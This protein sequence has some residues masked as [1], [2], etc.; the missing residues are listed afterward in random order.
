MTTYL[1][2][3]GLQL[4]LY[5]FVYERP[6]V[7]YRGFSQSF[8]QSDC[9][10]CILE[11]KTQGGDTAQL[12]VSNV[13]RSDLILYFH[14]CIIK[15][16]IHYSL[17]LFCNNM[18]Y[19]E[20]MQMHMFTFIYITDLSNLANHSLMIDFSRNFGRFCISTTAEPL[21]CIHQPTTLF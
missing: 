7:K 9:L 19:F 11:N 8:F 20:Y 12:W 4:L 17:S 21:T 10:L 13:S 1:R 14:T 5:I 3:A 6:S 15:A 18:L 16:R 2:L